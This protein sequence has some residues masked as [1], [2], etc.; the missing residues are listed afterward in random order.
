MSSTLTS[1]YATFLAQQ[2]LTALTN[3]NTAA[4]VFL[5]RPQEWSD[6][7][8]VLITDINPPVA[9]NTV[10][11]VTYEYWRDLLGI[12]RV[13]AANT[14]FVVAR[15]NWTAN[16]VYTQYD[17]LSSTLFAST[18]YVLDTNDTPYKVYKCLWNNHGAASTV[19]PSS[20]GPALNPGTTADEYVWQYMYSIGSENYKFLT[21]DWIPVLT[22][23]NVVD[24]A[25]T[26]SGRLPTA[27][28]LLVLDGG[29]GYNSAAQILITITGDGTGANATSN[30]VTMT[31]GVINSL[32]LASG[33]QGYTFVD[34]I[35]ITQ[36]GVSN[37]ASARA[38]IPPFPNHGANPV[39]E[40][41][42]RA[43]MLTMEFDSTESSELT[44]NNDF[45]RTGLLIN[46]LDAAGELANATFYRQTYDITFSA[47]T[48]I[49]A[50]DDVVENI[51]N[52]SHPTAIVVDVVAG[53]NATHIARLT[54]VNVKGNTT[55]FTLGDTIRCAETGAE[56]TVGTISSPELTPFSGSIIYVNNRTP[57]TRT[58]GQVE[59]IKIVFPY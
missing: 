8:D 16:T 53:A 19:A 34:S 37:T 35:A 15:H 31:D 18:F 20:L 39:A 28:P 7:N 32:T 25:N 51:T 24:N 4:Y 42:T 47:N 46:P 36:N 49:F 12:K 59:E 23:S 29:T 48:G 9:A 54:R 55:P 11:E 41:G 43:L 44:V 2:F 33:G 40:L 56:I 6:D 58:S 3:G 17:D 26:F 27:V 1:S 14:Q 57:V 45:R 5:G 13:S 22:D 21:S 52:V 10:Q 50:P 30:G 38:L